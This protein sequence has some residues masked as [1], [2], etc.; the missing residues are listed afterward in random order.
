MPYLIAYGIIALIFFIICLIVAARYKDDRI[1]GKGIKLTP[2]IA[3]LGG[4]FWPIILACI[5]VGMWED[6]VATCKSL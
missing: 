4:V 6:W 3:F 2:P 5:V 1:I